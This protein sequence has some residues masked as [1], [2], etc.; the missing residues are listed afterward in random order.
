MKALKILAGAVALGTLATP[1]L[2]ADFTGPRIEAHVGWDRVGIDS[3]ALGVDDHEDGIAYGAGLG[4]DFALTD[5]VIAGVEANIDFFDT[6]YGATVGTTAIGLEAK[7]D[8]DIS[9]RLGKKLTDNALFYVKAGYTNAR[10]K[11]S[12]TGGGVNIS[13][14]ENGDGV[15]VGAGL[16]YALTDNVYAKTEY[17]YSNYEGGFSRN[18]VLAGIGFRF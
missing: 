14:A 6:D 17:R 2:A 12:A 3:R 18:Q 11:A 10:L 16:E 8:F 4:Y 5:T 15:R 1:A 13:D 7:R 9:A